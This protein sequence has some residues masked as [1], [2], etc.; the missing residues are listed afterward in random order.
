MSSEYWQRVRDEAGRLGS[1]GCS[2]ATSAFRDCCFEHDIAYRTGATVDGQ[3]QT[4]QEADVRFRSC[5]Q[6]R[7][8]LGWYS[9]MAWIRY[10]LLQWKGQKAWD[11]NAES[12]AEAARRR[13]A[14]GHDDEAA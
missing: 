2:L 12:R 6:S 10:G 11:A 9:P 14:F 3:A 7:S 5:M 4:K 1:D 13:E 8:F